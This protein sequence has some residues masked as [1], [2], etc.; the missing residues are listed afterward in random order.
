MQNG[1]VTESRHPMSERDIQRL[2]ALLE[3][4]EQGHIA[5]FA[6]AHVSA[7]G[8]GWSHSA[9]TSQLQGAALIGALEGIKTD[10][11]RHT[12]ACECAQDGRSSVGAGSMGA[13]VR[14]GSAS[15]ER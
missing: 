13:T 11:V 6:I 15:T 8:V 3:A 10:M 1:D 9:F 4:A 12:V 7:A 14:A 2:R 5:C